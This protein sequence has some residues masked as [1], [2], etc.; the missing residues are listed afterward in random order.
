MGDFQIPRI[1]Y[2]LAKNAL[3]PKRNILNAFI[4]SIWSINNRR[5]IT[6]G[7]LSPHRLAFTLT[8]LFNTRQHPT[9][10]FYILSEKYLV[11]IYKIFNIYVKTSKCISMGCVFRMI[12]CTYLLEGVP[13]DM[14]Y[15]CVGAK[16]ACGFTGNGVFEGGCAPASNTQRSEWDELRNECDVQSVYYWASLWL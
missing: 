8:I 5:R 6:Q 14:N 12:W 15:K 1:V 11:Y 3:N 13:S 16:R 2:I 9:I 7:L 4:P 10:F